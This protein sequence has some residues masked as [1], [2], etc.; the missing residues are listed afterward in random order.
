MRCF[1]FCMVLVVSILAVSP[2]LAN[3]SAI[4]VKRVVNWQNRTIVFE[5]STPVDQQG[6]PTSKQ[7]AEGLIDRMR[8]RMIADSLSEVVFDSQG[9]FYLQG[10]TGNGVVWNLDA[11]AT[12]ARKEY[13]VFSSDFKT[14]FIAY[15][16]K[17]SD[18][19]QHITP[20]SLR[21]VM[22]LLHPTVRDFDYTG[23]VIYAAEPLPIRNGMNKAFLEPAL[24]PSILGANGEVIFSTET[25]APDV[26]RR[27]GSLAYS[28]SAL[29]SDWPVNKVGFNPLVISAT[30]VAGDF[31]TDIVLSNQDIYRL[32]GTPEALDLL[33]QGRVVV[34]IQHPREA[35]DFF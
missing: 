24:S 30:A 1:K 28:Y 4:Q 31:L 34:I 17:F 29:M 8:F 35:D 21:R 32:R 16:L 22:P 14:L 33:Y 23:I 11:V 25:I 3:S 12:L 19:T 15:T 26:F 2:L 6:L 5:L 9:S 27:Q 7:R 10:H 18:I 20:T 13:S